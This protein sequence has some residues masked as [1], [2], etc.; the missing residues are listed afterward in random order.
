M[1]SWEP[2]TPPP[3]RHP[4]HDA[5]A[6]SASALRRS[7]GEFASIDLTVI[8]RVIPLASDVGFA[9][10][11]IQLDS[12][13]QPPSVS[14]RTLTPNAQVDALV[15]GVLVGRESSS[16]GITALGCQPPKGVPKQLEIPRA[17]RC[18]HTKARPIRSNLR[19]KH[20][21]IAEDGDP[22][23]TELE[24]GTLEPSTDG[25][26]GCRRIDPPRNGVW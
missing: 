15:S 3:V 8:V 11:D 17:G 18:I 10:E 21:C 7:R 22:A 25:N 24:D 2:P 1:K 19:R 20:R 12:A 16:L 5:L 13:A 26:L 9:Y 23:P 6:Q 14:G 4:C